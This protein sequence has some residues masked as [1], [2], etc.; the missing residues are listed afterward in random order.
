MSLAALEQLRQPEAADKRNSGAVK[1]L[2]RDRAAADPR[3]QRERPQLKSKVAPSG[4]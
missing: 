2:R 1:N 3:D 4:S